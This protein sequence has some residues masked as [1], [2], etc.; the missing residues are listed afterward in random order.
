M[1][2]VSNSI[3]DPKHNGHAELLCPSYLSTWDEQDYF[4]FPT[5]KKP[6]NPNFSIMILSPITTILITSVLRNL[7]VNLSLS[8]HQFDWNSMV[9]RNGNIKINL[10]Y[11]KQATQEGCQSSGPSS[12]NLLAVTGSNTLNAQKFLCILLVGVK[13]HICGLNWEGIS[14][15][16]GQLTTWP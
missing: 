15:W 5:V 7:L 11:T 3:H 1:K 2:K 12:N 13:P 10:L 8:H 16:E 14:I 4:A 9:S 6:L